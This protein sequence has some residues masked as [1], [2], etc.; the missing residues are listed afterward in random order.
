MIVCLKTYMNGQD[1]N[2]HGTYDSYTGDQDK[3]DNTHMIKIH[4]SAH[5]Q[6]ISDHDQ[7]DQNPAY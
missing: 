5:D 7:Q 6:D 1:Q 4:L 2:Y 3:P